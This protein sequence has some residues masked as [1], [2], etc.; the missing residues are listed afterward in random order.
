MPG[1]LRSRNFAIVE[2]RPAARAA[3][4]TSRSRRR[5]P[6]PRGRPA[7]RW[8]PRGAPACRRCRGRRRSPRRGRARRCRRGRWRR[9]GARGS[10]RSCRTSSYAGPAAASDCD[11]FLTTPAPRPSPLAAA[12]GI[13]RS[14]RRALGAA[15]GCV[16]A[17]SHPIR[18]SRRRSMSG[19]VIV[20][21]ARTP[22][23]R[24]LGGLK[25]QSAADLG[26]RRDRGRAR[27]R[28]ASPATRS[29]T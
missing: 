2:A 11:L 9:R 4:C 28:P 24:L 21:G 19:S 29:T 5:R 10:R 6:S 14:P 16:Q 20:A 3:G 15:S 27:R 23:G 1:P 25:S 22:I 18:S 17:A 7:P 26:R 8:S 13:V 12:V